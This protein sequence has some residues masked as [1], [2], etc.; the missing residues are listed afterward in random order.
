VWLA[1]LLHAL[2]HPTVWK[3]ISPK[4]ICRTVHIASVLRRIRPL[5]KR[6]AQKADHY[7]LC[8]RI[9]L[10]SGAYATPRQDTD[11]AGA[12]GGQEFRPRVCY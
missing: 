6:E 12:G 5:L 7:I 11:Y 2:I 3:G 9:K 10:R 4:S 1:S 8:V